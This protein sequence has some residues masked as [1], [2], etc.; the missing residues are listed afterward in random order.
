LLRAGVPE[1]HTW[2]C[3]VRGCYEYAP[4]GG[5]STGMN[6]TNL[7]KPLEYALHEGRDGVTGVFSGQESPP[8]S[9]YTNFDQL[10][11]A[12]K[13]Q[14]LA[15]LDTVMEVNMGYDGYLHTINPLSM[16]SA[17][18]PSCLEKAKDALGGGSVTNNSCLE[19]GYLAD[20]VDSLRMIQKYVY[21][22]Q[23]LTLPQLVDMLDHN[24]AGNERWQARL[25]ADREKYGNNKPRPDAI[26]MELVRLITDHV[27]GKP[28]S[29]VRG[30]S[31]ICSFTVARQSYDQGKKTAASANGR[32]LGE[33]LSKNISPSMGQNRE[34]ATAAIL[35]ATKLDTSSLRGDAPLDIGLLPSAVQGAD[36]LEAMYGLV[37]TFLRRGGHAIHMN[38]F[39]AATLRDAQQH[40]EQYR[41]LQI[42]VCGWNVLWNNICRQEQD[43]FIR[44]AESLV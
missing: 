28:N 37:M 6:Y 5:Y 22:K 43:A 35:S 11:A 42:R 39:D 20:A 10:F 30:G 14:L 18:F 17:T 13:R 26:A 31:W 3:D 34:G 40:P 25:R 33:E 8:L 4:R 21:E 23:E 36:G 24:F 44:Q 7:L 38:V 32:G 15:L 27:C 41:D 2:L 19:S 12:Y 9:C 29:P 16:L 1:A